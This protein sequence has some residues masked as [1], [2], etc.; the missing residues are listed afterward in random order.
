MDTKKA[1]EIKKGD[2]IMVDGVAREVT[3]ARRH[4]RYAGYMAIQYDAAGAITQGDY[5]ADMDVEVSP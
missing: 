1:R 4:R 3:D 2:R 5:R